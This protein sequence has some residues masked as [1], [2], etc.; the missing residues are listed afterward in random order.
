MKAHQQNVQRVRVGKFGRKSGFTLIEL[1]VVI[2]IIA[3]LAAL[4]LPA[5]ANAKRQAQQVKCLSNQKQLTY[6]WLLY[7]SDYSGQ[8]AINANN[9]A[10]GEGIV[11]WVAD[12]MSWDF[13]PSPSNPQNTNTLYLANALLGPYC[14]KAVGIYKCPGDNYNGAKGP[15]VRSISMNGQMNGNCGNDSEAAINLNQY[16]AGQ[17]YRIFRKEADM[18]GPTPA[19]AWVFIDEHPDSINDGFFKVDM[20]TGDNLW[21]DWPASN[22]GGSGALSFADGHAEVHKWTD[23][24][25]ANQPVRYQAAPATNATPPYTDLRW[26]QLRTT[27]LQ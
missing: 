5:L 3:I 16:G 20:K 24:A 1:L 23:P 19:N 18:I 12:V 13:P 8:L 25:I 4:L 27:A 26:L 22:H 14:A 2:A 15:R 7:S 10:I 9:V 11:G 17:D 21:P 6:A